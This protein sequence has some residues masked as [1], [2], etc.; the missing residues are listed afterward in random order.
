MREIADVEKR[1][2]PST[3]SVVGRREVQM[4][5]KM[6]CPQHANGAGCWRTL[7]PLEEAHSKLHREVFRLAHSL[8]GH[9][10]FN[11]EALIR[12]ARDASKRRYDLYF[13]AG[14]VSI[15]DQWGPL[16]ERP[17]AEILNQIEN[18]GA[19]IIMKH[20]EQDPGYAKIMEEFTEF[21]QKVA[22]PEKARF[23]R[24]PELQ[25]LITSPNRIT[26]VHFD[27][28][29]NFL[30][31]IQGSK[32][33]WVCDPLDRS[34]VTE[35]EIERYY[36]MNINSG[37]YKPGLESR[38][39][40]F[41]LSPG[42]AV[43][44]PTHAAHWVKNSDTVSISLSLNFEFPGWMYSHVYR[45]NHYLRKLGM[46]PRPPGQSQVGDSVKASIMGTAVHLYKATRQFVAG[47]K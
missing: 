19:W 47:K 2:N 9:P 39:T 45:A 20:V 30:V 18:A 25:V 13:D 26:P 4:K 31:Q 35:L 27:P 14:D 16:P 33:L 5:S 34:I 29:V 11:F 24:N 3:S 1:A 36:G 7:D 12:V 22:G 42:E 38:A 28:E 32:D 40:R 8:A 23:L 37:I 10:L 43:H 21:V 17:V 15:S 6:T 46:R 44:I 41:H